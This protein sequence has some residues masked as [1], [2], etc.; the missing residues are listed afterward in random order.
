MVRQSE[1]E[2]APKSSDSAWYAGRRVSL[3]TPME[4]SS[5]SATALSCAVQWLLSSRQLLSSSAAPVP[6]SSSRVKSHASVHSF[7]SGR[8]RAELPRG[9]TLV[10]CPGMLRRNLRPRFHRLDYII[11][12]ARSLD[13][14][15]ISL[16]PESGGN[17]F[18]ETCH[19]GCPEW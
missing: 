18:P 4:H 8:A 6:H 11:Y 12:S 3:G 14:E 2:D 1:S 13:A 19:G 7:A 9:H 15:S 5:L 16:Q 17:R 10:A